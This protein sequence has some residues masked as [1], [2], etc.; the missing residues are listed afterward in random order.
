MEA[1]VITAWLKREVLRVREASE[2]PVGEARVPIRD[3]TRKRAERKQRVTYEEYILTKT[4]TVKN[5]KKRD[6]K[7]IIQKISKLPLAA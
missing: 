2:S 7:K 5:S 3:E 1:W 4:V 6:C